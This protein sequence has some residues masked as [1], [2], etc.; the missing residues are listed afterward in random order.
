MNTLVRLMAGASAADWGALANFKATSK[1][2]F[3]FDS[4]SKSA[5]TA[6]CGPPPDGICWPTIF[7]LGGSSPKH[8]FANMKSTLAAYE[9]ELNAFCDRIRWKYHFTDE[10]KQDLFV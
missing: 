7:A 8:R 6:D 2:V 9:R 3:L 10:P 5:R 1:Q 4:A